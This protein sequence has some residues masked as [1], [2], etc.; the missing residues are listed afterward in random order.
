MG[1]D[2]QGRWKFQKVQ[3]HQP[4][5]NHE[6]HELVAEVRKVPIEGER[7]APCK[8]ESKQHDH[9]GAQELWIQF[10]VQARGRGWNKTGVVCS[11]MLKA[12]VKRA[13]L[14]LCQT[15]GSQHTNFPANTPSFKQKGERQAWSQRMKRWRAKNWKE[16]VRR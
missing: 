12:S 4:G 15:K 11:T 14:G 3:W 1:T 9:G 8:L 7:S 5:Q 16:V 2:W 13:D 6:A 10:G